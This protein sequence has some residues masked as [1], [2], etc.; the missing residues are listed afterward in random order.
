MWSMCLQAA[1]AS[2]VPGLSYRTSQ[3]VK[4]FLLGV[5]LVDKVRCG[6]DMHWRMC[7]IK[8]TLTYPW[9]S[10]IQRNVPALVA[11]F[12]AAMKSWV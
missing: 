1:S 9:V 11:S 7:Q 3:A 12:R 5:H 4:G 6:Q 10:S 2:C 8:E